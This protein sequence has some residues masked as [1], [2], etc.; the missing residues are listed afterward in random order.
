MADVPAEL[1]DAFAVDLHA[2]AEALRESVVPKT[3]TNRESTWKVWESF[4]KSMGYKPFLSNY[5]GDPI[6]FFIVFAMRYR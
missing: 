3:R 2:G 1:R 5:E 6:D 4:T